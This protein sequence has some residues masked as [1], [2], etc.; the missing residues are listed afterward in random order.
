[1][2]QNGGFTGL[3]PEIRAALIE[4]PASMSNISESFRGEL[5]NQAM[6]SAY[7]AELD[8]ISELERAIE[9]TAS[10]LGETSEEVRRQAI[11]ADPTNSDADVYAA[12]STQAAGVADALWLKKF[13]EAGVEVIR[14]AKWNEDGKTGIWA[15]ATDED[16]A[17]GLFAET[18]D[19]FDKL[20]AA[21]PIFGAG[22]EGRTARAAFVD[23]H[24]LDA[25]LNRNNVV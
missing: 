11:E 23:E 10:A 8:Q 3:N 12:R 22:D 20:K 1:M 16:I 18:R 6:Q 13:N 5:L 17:N 15:K 25:Y 21:A 9:I 19:E 24:G 14:A 7:G 2:K 4:M